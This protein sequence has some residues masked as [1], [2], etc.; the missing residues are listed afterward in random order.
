MLSLSSGE[1]GSRQ[2]RSLVRNLIQ[3]SLLCSFF[4]GCFFSCHMTI[5]RLSPFFTSTPPFPSSSKLTFRLRRRR[6]CN[7]SFPRPFSFAN[8]LLGHKM[9]NTTIASMTYHTSRTF[10]WCPSPPP[11]LGFCLLLFLPPVVSVFYSF[12]SSR[13]FI[14]AVIFP[15][16]V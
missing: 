8:L 9:T 1:L 5:A 11:L 2:P 4:Q 3:S 15:V 7:L 12:P 13:R 16:W 10:I 14:A 6:P